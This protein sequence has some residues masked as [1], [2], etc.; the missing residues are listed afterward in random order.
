[1]GDRVIELC[2]YWHP[3]GFW[4]LLCWYA[5]LPLYSPL[6]HTA[7]AEIARQLSERRMQATG[8]NEFRKGDQQVNGKDEDFSH[9]A[10][11]TI[12]AG[13][14]NTARRVRVASHCE[15]ATHRQREVQ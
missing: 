5:H 8:A 13:T 12:T 1:M 14:C 6:V 7:A 3:A 15:F 9:R 11:R 2:A 10:N 4:G